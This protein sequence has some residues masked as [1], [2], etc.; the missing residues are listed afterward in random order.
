MLPSIPARNRR[1]RNAPTPERTTTSATANA[2]VTLILIG[3]RFTR[4]CLGSGARQA[5]DEVTAIGAR[6]GLHVAA[7]GTGKAPRQRQSE[8]RSGCGERSD[9]V[10]G[11]APP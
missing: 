6:L 1:Y 5:H 7:G 11:C 10:G 2:A 3:T 8:S 9:P 4:V